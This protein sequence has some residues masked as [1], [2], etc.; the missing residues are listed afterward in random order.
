MRLQ[1]ASDLHFEHFENTQNVDFT[2][3]IIPSTNIL[4]LAG[5][6]STYD[7]KLLIP[8]LK[9]CSCNF[10]HILWVPGNHEYYNTKGVAISDLDIFYYNA[11]S[12][13]S[14]IYFLN[15]R[16][17]VLDNIMFIGTTLWSYIHHENAKSVRKQ[18]NDFKYIYSSEGVKV[19][20]PDVNKLYETNMTFIVQE[21]KK[22]EG[23]PV[24][25]THHAPANKG[26][27]LPVYENSITNCAFASD[28]LSSD[29][30]FPPKLWIHGHTHYNAHHKLHQNGYELVSNQYGYEGEHDGLAYN[31]ACVFDLG[32]N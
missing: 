17:I 31:R 23:A 29:L 6:I 32:G 1:I 14:N 20:I 16:S 19:K 3:I 21:L 26:T 15:N 25:I 11:C 2:D 30:P 27:S 7:C 28:I 5:D 10:E 24:V 4:A 13:F 18:I 12:Q 8:F 22:T 9:W